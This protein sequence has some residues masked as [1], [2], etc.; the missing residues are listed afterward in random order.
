MMKD[1]LRRLGL[2]S[3]Q[4]IKVTTKVT[5]AGG[6]TVT[7]TKTVTAQKPCGRQAPQINRR[8]LRP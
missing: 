4:E 1:P 5:P 8:E 7:T 3:L 6:A 2:A